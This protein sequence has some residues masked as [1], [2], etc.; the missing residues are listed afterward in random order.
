MSF[1]ISGGIHADRLGA[2]MPA[3][4]DERDRQDARRRDQRRCLWRF[5]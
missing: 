2:P 5:D 4:F 3:R 1:E